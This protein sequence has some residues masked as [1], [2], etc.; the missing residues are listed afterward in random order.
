MVESLP[1]E[2]GAGRGIEFEWDVYIWGQ[3][4][5]RSTDKNGKSCLKLLPFKAIKRILT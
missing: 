1:V 3:I 5:V 2:Y 4:A